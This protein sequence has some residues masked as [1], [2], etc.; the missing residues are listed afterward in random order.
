MM[1]I[2]KNRG[3]PQHNGQEMRRLLFL[4]PQVPREFHQ[5]CQHE[6]L[7]DNCDREQVVLRLGAKSLHDNCGE[8]ASRGH[9]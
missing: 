3:Q 7:H 9:N 4:F 2:N 1:K 6:R 8:C 5:I